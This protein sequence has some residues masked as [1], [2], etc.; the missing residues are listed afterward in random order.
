[1]QRSRKKSKCVVGKRK[2]VGFVSTTPPTSET[3][4][5]YVAVLG[6][7]L[8]QHEFLTSELDIV[9]RVLEAEARSKSKRCKW[10]ELV[11]V[12]RQFVVESTHPA[13]GHEIYL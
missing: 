3:A 13:P 1:M 7:P 11:A 2:F 8:V 6:T 10:K 4:H 5:Q 12:L 9:L